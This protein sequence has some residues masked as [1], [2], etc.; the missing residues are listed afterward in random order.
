VEGLPVT[1]PSRKKGTSG[2]GEV[3]DLWNDYFGCPIARRNPASAKFDI[4]VSEKPALHPPIE[5]LATRPDRGEW[6]VTLRH[7]DFMEVFGDSEFYRT[8]PVHIEVKRYSRFA[9]HEI[10]RK[11]F[12]KGK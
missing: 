11:K 9:H 10:F 4:T 2:E 1:N 5:V 8:T 12:G 7:S 6:L 3:V